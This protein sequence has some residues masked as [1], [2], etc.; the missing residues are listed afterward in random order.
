MGRKSEQQIQ[1]QADLKKFKEE[2]NS[3]LAQWLD[4]V[5]SI[6][7]VCLEGNERMNA[8]YNLLLDRLIFN[9]PQTATL[10]LDID[11]QNDLSGAIHGRGRALGQIGFIMGLQAGVRFMR[12][13][14]S[15]RLIEELIAKEIIF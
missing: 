6:A 12:D 1:Y 11:T 8:D 14:E 15:D 7:E 2:Q 13:I 10:T 4:S 3:C 9:Q 5:E